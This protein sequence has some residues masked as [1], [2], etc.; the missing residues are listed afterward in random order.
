MMKQTGLFGKVTSSAKLRKNRSA[1]SVISSEC[2]MACYMAEELVC[3][4]RCNGKFHGKG[5]PSFNKNQKRLEVENEHGDY[6]ILEG[7]R[8]A[9]EAGR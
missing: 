7:L 3:T 1:K 6:D 5:N 4:C 9:R 8:R 2:C